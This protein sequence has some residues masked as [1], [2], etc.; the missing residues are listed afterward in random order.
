[1]NCVIIL[2]GDWKMRTRHMLQLDKGRAKGY[3]FPWVQPSLMKMILPLVAVTCMPRSARLNPYLNLSTWGLT[4]FT[5]LTLGLI[6]CTAFSSYFK[7]WVYKNWCNCPTRSSTCPPCAHPLCRPQLLCKGKAARRWVLGVFTVFICLTQL[8][9]SPRGKDGWYLCVW[10]I[11]NHLIEG[12]KAVPWFSLALHSHLHTR[13]SV[14]VYFTSIQSAENHSRR[15][16][17]IPAWGALVSSDC[18]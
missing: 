7:R 14:W 12:E 17:R 8:K 5:P 6:I 11:H 18:K 3:A 13:R 4:V 2:W 15:Y 10:M 1:M 16:W 9:M